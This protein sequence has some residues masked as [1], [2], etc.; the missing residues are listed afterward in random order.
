MNRS[1]WR[2]TLSLALLALAFGARGRAQLVQDHPGQYSQAD[3]DIGARVYNTQCAQCH[4]PNGDQVSGIDLRRGQFR[5]A[6]SDDD[7]ARIISNGVP[8]TGMPPFALQPPEMIGVIA[9]IRAGFDPAVRP[10]KIGSAARGE[11]IV[12]GSGGCL[13]CHRINDRGSRVGPDLSDIGAARNAEA[14]HRSL[15]D[16]TSGMM[17]INRP[18]RILMKDGRTISGRRLNE[19]TY[20]VQLI[21]EKEQLHSLS[22]SDMRTYVVETKS[23][24]PSYAGR[25]TPEELSDVIA[26]LLT[27]KG[28]QP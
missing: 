17:P 21:D 9:F 14:I 1:L 4:G 26:Y 6:S 24:M 28:L 23:T 27:L 8:G 12:L 3:I 11:P 7:L 10:I 13:A 5:R 20:T 15:I 25:L 16:P 18:V 22:K 19:D 2:F